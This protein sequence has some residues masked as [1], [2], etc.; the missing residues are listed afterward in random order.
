MTKQALADCAWVLQNQRQDV[1]PERG[2]W[3]HSS[4]DEWVPKSCK[5]FFSLWWKFRCWAGLSQ[6]VG[7]RWQVWLEVLPSGFRFQ[8]KNRTNHCQ[9]RLTLGKLARVNILEIYCYVL[10]IIILSS[11]AFHFLVSWGK[12]AK[13]PQYSCLENP[14]GQRTLAYWSP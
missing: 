14:Q 3:K 11:L 12:W 2:G 10:F 7:C 1:G 13:P 8:P 6:V 9:L 5:C 4:W